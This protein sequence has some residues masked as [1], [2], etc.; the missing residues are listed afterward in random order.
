MLFLISSVKSGIFNLE[1]DIEKVMC[2]Y[3]CVLVLPESNNK[4]IILKKTYGA[5]VSKY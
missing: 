2:L 4:I 5:Q 3:L 1:Y